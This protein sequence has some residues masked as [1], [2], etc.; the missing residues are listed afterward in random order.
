MAKYK[1]V[2]HGRNVLMCDEETG[3]TQRAGF[4]VICCVDAADRESAGTTALDILKRHPRYVSLASWPRGD[5]S[6]RPEIEV[7]AVDA[8]PRL[9]RRIAPGITAGFT[10]YVEPDETIR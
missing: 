10:F 1:V 2:L 4:H 8:M 6:G 7:E 3:K 9:S 5:G